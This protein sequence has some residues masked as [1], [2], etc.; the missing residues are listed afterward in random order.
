MAVDPSVLQK[1]ADIAGMLIPEEEDEEGKKKENVGT[2][3]AKGA[4]TGL[5]TGA[6]LGTQV[7]PGIGTAIGALAG[8]ILGGGIGAAK[9]GKAVANR[10]KAAQEEGEARVAEDTQGRALNLSNKAEARAKELLLEEKE[11][12]NEY[13]V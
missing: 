13:N 11:K 3:A 1:S 8:L 6:A 5:S 7:F 10:R 2:G 9:G 12:Y 4:L